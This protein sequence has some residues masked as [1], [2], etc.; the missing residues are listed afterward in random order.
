M[1]D[2]SFNWRNPLPLTAVT[3]PPEA[4]RELCNIRD[5]LRL[6]AA[7][8]VRQAQ[9]RPKVEMCRNTLAHCFDHLANRVDEV[10]DMFGGA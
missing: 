4:Y 9:R 6:F 10:V 3:L 2:E 5:E 7:M 1:A 8:T